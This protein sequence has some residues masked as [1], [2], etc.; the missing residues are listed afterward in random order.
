[1]PP[2]LPLFLGARP[3]AETALQRGLKY[4][5]SANIVHC[6]LTPSSILVDHKYDARI[7]DLGQAQLRG[8]TITN[9]APTRYSSAPE[10]LLHQQVYDGG[11]DMWSAGC[12]LAEMLDG[13]VMFATKDTKLNRLCTI[14]KLIGKADSL[15]HVGPT[16]VRH[17][18]SP[19]AC[20]LGVFVLTICSV[21]TSFDGLSNACQT[22][23]SNY[24]VISSTVW[25]QQVR[26][27][28]P[29]TQSQ[30][31]KKDQ[32]RT[33]SFFKTALAVDLLEH[34]ITFDPAG[35]YQANQALGHSY[36]AVCHEPSDE[37]TSAKAWEGPDFDC[38]D[39]S[40]G[41]W[42]NLVYA[43]NLN[44]RLCLLVCVSADSFCL[45]SLSE[46]LDYHDRAF[47]SATRDATMV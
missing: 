29:M 36:L 4:L 42:R 45:S 25:T 16:E 21:P 24:A 28:E 47:K 44:S 14:T 23:N 38:K 26:T 7:T 10:V 18:R 13:H 34:L 6:N 12:I 41:V 31:S 17:T 46:I 40:A 30:N 11:I 33:D 5:H 3:L 19:C 27:R 39:L 32:R 37:P 35:R 2:E 22:K 15:M 1:M 9:F 43:S 8:T 20:F